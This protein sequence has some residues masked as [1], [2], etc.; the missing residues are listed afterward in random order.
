MVKKLVGRMAVVGG[1]G[2]G[3]TG[4]LVLGE[5]NFEF[6]SLSKARYFEDSY[7]LIVER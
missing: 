2:M 1:A 6:G 5:C 4:N 3:M 7:R